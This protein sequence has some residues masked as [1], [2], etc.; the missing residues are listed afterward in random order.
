MGVA[1][2]ADHELSTL[3]SGEQQRVFL[4]RT[5]MNDPAVLLLD[6]PAARLDLGGREQLVAAL[7][8][9]AGHRE[10]PPMVLVTH[11]VDEVPPNLTHVLLLRRGQVLAQGPIAETLTSESVSECFGLRLKLERR[12]DGRWA[13]WSIS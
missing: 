10:S 1:A 7:D 2:L 6:E 13:A 4:A 8:E 9:L 11:Y 3:S 5:L 12:R